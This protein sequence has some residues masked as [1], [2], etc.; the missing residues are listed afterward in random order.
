[1]IWI[2]APAQGV[3]GDSLHTTFTYDFALGEHEVT[4][5]EFKT[6]LALPPQDSLHD[7]LPVSNVSFEDAVRY[8]NALS[9]SKG[10]DSVYS[11]SEITLAADGSVERMDGLLTDLSKNGYRLPTE[12][13]WNLAART[14]KGLAYP[15]GSALK[16]AQD[17]AWFSDNAHGHLHAICSRKETSKGF[18]DLSGNVKEWTNDWMDALPTDTVTDFAG[19]A[20]PTADMQHVIKGGSY[21]ES[22]LQQSVQA[23]MDVYPLAPA[24]RTKYLGFRVARGAIAHPQFRTS[25]GNMGSTG[26]PIR[27]TATRQQI[28]D[29]FGT[30]W[31]RLALVNGT[32][33]HLA[34]IDY[35]SAEIS[36]REVPEVATYPRIHP[37]GKWLVYGTRREGQGGTS[38]T[39]IR[40]FSPLDS[41]SFTLADSLAFMPHWWINPTNKQTTLL[42]TNTLASNEDS[43][44][45][46]TQKTWKRNFTSDVPATQSVA[47]WVDGSYHSGISKD[48]RWLVDASPILRVFDRND[49]SIRTLFQSPENGKPLSGSIQVCNASVSPDDS[50]QTPRVMFL[51]FGS[52][53]SSTIV[54]RSYG[55]HEILFLA[56]LATGNI[57]DWIAPPSPYLAWDHPQ[58]SSDTGYAIATVTDAAELHPALY[59]IRLRDHAMLK[60]A[61][62][63]D[64]QMPA[65]WMKGT[66][67]GVD[68][69][70]DSL[71]MYHEPLTQDHKEIAAKMQ[72]FWDRY[73]SVELVALGSSR[74]RLGFNPRY[75][76]QLKSINMSISGSDLW[77][78]RMFWTSYIR[79]HAKNLKVLVL[80]F[81]LDLLLHDRTNGRDLMYT[82]NK[83]YQYDKSRNFWAMSGPPS[84]TSSIMR[85][86]NTSIPINTTDTNGY[87][88]MRIGAWGD[89]MYTLNSPTTTI[90]QEALDS[91]E[92]VITEAESRNIQVLG[93]IFPQNPRYATTQSWG[94]Y[95]PNQEQAAQIM[96]YIQNIENRHPKFI[97]MDENKNGA[98]DYPDSLAYDFDH[99]DSLGAR[100][101]TSRVDS[102]L[103]SLGL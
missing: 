45:W 90:W 95:G 35:S 31:V 42:Y 69:N 20:Q 94:R 102:V 89:T 34:M 33:G 25:D 91:I 17:Y 37:E 16:G 2:A 9:K 70:F 6:L 68:E 83:G 48:G 75:I 57:T 41:P 50:T 8:C 40:P 38:W 85:N 99:L 27:I 5:G 93:I 103:K 15:W 62:G 87:Q 12:A 100:Q 96:S 97:L 98:H 1:M 101:L 66:D 71:F 13:E 60:L 24:N 43:A 51:D 54:H 84:N 14:E 80:E 76:S 67:I 19:A 47:F 63:E 29:F 46:V 92:D 72:I 74:T 55:I 36:V 73:D 52:T 32:N 65:L 22:G 49:R 30:R 78:Q 4:Q 7:S 81:S 10:F 53:D 59:A 21:L 3:L 26:S 79:I 77:V 88:S 11:Y 58:W 86:Q 39:T 18:C 64:L 61:E 28:F 82:D 56:N 23:R 44:T